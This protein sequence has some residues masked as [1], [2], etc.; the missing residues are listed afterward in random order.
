MSSGTR[1]KEAFD[2]IVNSDKEYIIGIDEVGYGCVAGPIH[3]CAFLAPKDWT[4]KG[5]DDSKALTKKTREL[6]CEE[7]SYLYYD[8]FTI[9]SVHPNNLEEYKDYGTNVHG[10]LKYLY[11]KAVDDLTDRLVDRVNKSLIVLDGI[12]K[13]PEH[14]HSLGE[15]ISLPK[16]DSLIP[17]VSAASILAKVHRDAYMK[18]L[19]KK[20]PQ[21]GWESNKGYPSS[22]H[23]AALKKYSYC[24]EHRKGY[25]PIK[26][27]IKQNG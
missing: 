19:A 8:Y 6:I 12:I 7:L 26:S 4:H 21:Y 13:F 2:A 3:V 16:A 10:A 1:S 14:P 20:Y 27:M 25:E 15:A 11:W 5:I 23:K 24:S 22:G 18:E 17:Q 9:V